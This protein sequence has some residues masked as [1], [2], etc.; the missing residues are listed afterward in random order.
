MA[1]NN[2]LTTNQIAVLELLENGEI[3]SYE[4]PRELHSVFHELW[5][6]N[7]K[8]GHDHVEIRYCGGCE[9]SHCETT[10]YSINDNGRAA[11]KAYRSHEH[12][13]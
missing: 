9:C 8:Q 12:G 3:E 4:L 5:S 13:K 2:E 1:I 7:S 11:L 6:V 10:F